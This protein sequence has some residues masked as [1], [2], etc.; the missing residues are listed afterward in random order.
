MIVGQMEKEKKKFR[1]LHGYIYL[2]PRIK[3]HRKHRGRLVVCKNKLH[4]LIPC[5]F[6]FTLFSLVP[7]SVRAVPTS[8][9]LTARKGGSVTLECKAAGNPVPS[10]HWS[11]KVI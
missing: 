6:F 2:E 5:V 10:I 11:K 1:H 9:Q 8:G 7:P 4:S 3:F